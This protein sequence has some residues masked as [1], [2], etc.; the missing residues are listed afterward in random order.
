MKTLARFALTI[1]AFLLFAGCGVSQGSGGVPGA[2]GS[3]MQVAPRALRGQNLLYVADPGRGSVDVLTY[4]QGKS[5]GAFYN[6][7][8]AGECV[9]SAG[10]VF[11]A[12]YQSA[13]VLIFERGVFGP[14]VIV[15]DPGYDAQGCSIDPTTGDLAVTNSSN[16]S[17]KAGSVAIYANFSEP[18][19]IYTIPKFY[20]YDYCGYD[21]DGNLFV[22]GIDSKEPLPHIEF[23]E[24]IK[25]GSSF[26]NIKVEKKLTSPGAVQWDGTY[27]ALGDPD[28]AVLYRLEI[29]GS[30]AKVVGTTRFKG[31]KP[32]GQFWI[33]P[34]IGKKG[35]VLVSRSTAG[36]TYED[37][38]Y[39]KYPAGGSAIKT[40]SND[41]RAPV[42][43]TVSVA[44]Y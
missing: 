4:P 32:L 11:V 41:F 8:P 35:A 7:T 16:F 24:L 39:W 40:I 20:Y 33:V 1:G 18:P 36:G 3:S 28:A 30:R 29:S 26:S 9:D 34:A 12:D 10:D 42:G 44:P 17:S 37:V 2:T 31:P 43:I 27:I 22:D 25:G 23:A 13:E 19:T 15:N 14:P 5:V 6:V 21:N 38:A